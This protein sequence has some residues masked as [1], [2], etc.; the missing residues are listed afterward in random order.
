MTKPFGRLSEDEDAESPNVFLGYTA[1]ASKRSSIGAN[2]YHAY[3][4]PIRDSSLSDSRILSP[5]KDEGFQYA[6]F[7]TV[8]GVA[9]HL[10]NKSLTASN[11]H[12]INSVPVTTSYFGQS[13]PS[14]VKRDF[15]DIE[16]PHAQEVIDIRFSSTAE[17]NSEGHNELKLGNP[18]SAEGIVDN[19][20]STIILESHSAYERRDDIVYV[21]TQMLEEVSYTSDTTAKYHTFSHTSY[22]SNRPSFMQDDDSD[23]ESDQ[24]EWKEYLL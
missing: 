17:S 1:S 18:T 3:I 14:F 19:D 10:T 4:T 15:G 24:V 7:G 23:N 16:E 11:I 20:I 8:V 5:Q 6:E 21:D 13:L 9:S 12:E 2:P 22:Y